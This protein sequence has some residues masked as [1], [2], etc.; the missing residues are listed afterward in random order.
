MRSPHNLACTDEINRWTS[1]GSSWADR[2]FDPAIEAWNA[3]VECFLAKD[4][5]LQL[6]LV[7]AFHQAY[8]TLDLGFDILI[9]ILLGENGWL[10]SA[11]A[12]IL[13]T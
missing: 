2:V 8:Q 1:L 3:K 12:L 5:A 7:H 11:T 13:T 6:L 10:G 9:E 4:L